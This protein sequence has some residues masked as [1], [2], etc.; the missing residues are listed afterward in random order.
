[1]FPSKKDIQYLKLCFSIS[2]IFSTCSKKQYGAILVDEK[3][4][5]VGFG[6]N[7]SPS[8]YDHCSDGACPRVFENSSS[9]SHYD[10]A[11]RYTPT[12]CIPSF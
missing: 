4:H 7:G 2:D 5:V 1:L 9:R 10:T 3:N 6:Y 11:Y 8:G 12:K